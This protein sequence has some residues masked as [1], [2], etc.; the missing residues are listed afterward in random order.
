[1]RPAVKI[2]NIGKEYKRAS[3][4]GT[5]YNRTARKLFLDMFRT[6]DHNQDDYNKFWALKS[7]NFEVN[8]GEVFGIVGSNGAGKSTLLKILAGI[9]SPT[10]GRAEVRGRVGA[11]LEIGTGFHPELTGRENV[12]LNGALLGMSRSEIS[13]HFDEIVDFSGIEDFIDTSVKFYSSGMLVRL[14]FSVAAHLQPE[15]LVIDEVLAVGDANFRTRCMGKI[16]EL[17]GSGRT[18]L[19]VSHNMSILSSLCTRAVE[20]SRGRVSAVGPVDSI[21]ESYLKN[22]SSED[23]VDKSFEKDSTKRVQIQRLRIVDQ[24]EKPTGLLKVDS[25]ITLQ[26]EILANESCQGSVSAMLADVRGTRICLSNAA[27][28]LEEYFT[29]IK[30]D[31]K[32]LSVTFP[33]GILNEGQYKFI[34]RT[35]DMDSV[36]FDSAESSFFELIKFDS[37]MSFVGERKKANTILSMPM[38]W[39][40]SPS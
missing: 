5:S 20:L 31:T 30:G 22:A 40:E 3:K 24:T 23:N 12:F 14:G 19:F 8:Q 7:I 35:T 32:S 1:M 15:V 4:G 37:K 6:Q 26:I 9:T 13:S 39:K 18:I 2:S 11:L 17:G 10:T 21:I 36:S 27:N 33:S 16:N 25:S 28:E 29:F 34:V 38:E